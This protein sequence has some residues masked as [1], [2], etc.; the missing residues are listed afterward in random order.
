MQVLMKET[1]LDHKQNWNF[2]WIFGFSWGIAA[3]K[4][5]ML[6]AARGNEL[7]EGMQKDLNPNTAGNTKL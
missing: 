3:F 2:I 7:Q 4:K 5:N 1:G 6:G